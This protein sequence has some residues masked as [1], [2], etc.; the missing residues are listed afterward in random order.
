M[1]TIQSYSKQFPQLRCNALSLTSASEAGVFFLE[2]YMPIE[3]PIDYRADENGCHVC[4]SH[5]KNTHGYPM[6]LRDGKNTHIHRHVFGWTYG[7]IPPGM[8]VCHTCDNRAC[9]NP[10]HFFL[11]TKGDNN[12]DR[13]QQ[14]RGR[15][16]RGTANGSTKLTEEQVRKIFVSSSSYSEIEREYGTCRANISHIKN[17]TTWS[18]LTRAD[19]K[20][21]EVVT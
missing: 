1:S 17:G 14:G 20:Q 18:W 10:E 5:S 9:I 8:C 16:L 15:Q 2:D 12:K 11:G 4:V 7:P 19:L 21:A 13:A 6:A 3:K